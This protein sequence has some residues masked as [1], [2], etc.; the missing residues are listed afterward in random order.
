MLGAIIGD[1]V[2]SCYEWDNIK[3]KDFEFVTARSKFTDDTVMTCAVAKALMLSDINDEENVKIN[4]IEQMI[5][6]GRKYPNAGYGGM[7]WKWLFGNDWA[8]Y[9]SYGN[10]SAM[11]VSSAGWI[12]N[13]MDVVLRVAKNTAEVTHSHPEGIKGAQA[14]A[15]AIL[16]ARQKKSMKEI[17]DYMQNNFYCL[18]FTLDQ[19]R[20]TYRFKASCQETVPQAIV[21][22]LESTGF[23]DAIRN[24][25]SIGGDSDTLAAITGSIAQ[26]YYGVS[27]E[28]REMALGK[29]DDGLRDIVSGFE[30]LSN[31][32][33]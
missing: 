21:A 10:G 26:G 23:E 9:N 33:L 7:F 22:F 8:P 30:G 19:I 2:G 5:D 25:V 1:I 13:D 18:D 28:M 4:V 20:P 17:R 15:A 14:T 6:I 12:S 24:A 31:K 27:V 16:L 11:R 32:L 29:L 3:T